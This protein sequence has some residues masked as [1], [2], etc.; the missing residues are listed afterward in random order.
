MRGAFRGTAIAPTSSSIDLFE[1]QSSGAGHSSGEAEGQRRVWQGITEMDLRQVMGHTARLN[2]IYEVSRLEEP[3]YVRGDS[4]G[5]EMRWCMSV[6]DCSFMSSSRGGV[7]ASCHLKRH[8]LLSAASS[9][10]DPS[11]GFCVCPV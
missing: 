11:S 6:G 2:T 1:G 9:R 10:T 7:V 8:C 5:N 3:I 4:D